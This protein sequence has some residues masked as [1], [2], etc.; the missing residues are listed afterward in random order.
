MRG[1]WPHAEGQPGEGTQN[2]RGTRREAQ[3][4]VPRRVSAPCRSGHSGGCGLASGVSKSKAP[5]GN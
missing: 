1:D 5:D 4:R 3:G 2:P